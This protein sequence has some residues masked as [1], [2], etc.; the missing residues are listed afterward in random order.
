MKTQALRFTLILLSTLTL[1]TFIPVSVAQIQDYSRVN[2]P[3]GAIVRLGKGGVSYRDRG[4]AFSPDGTKLAIG[5]GTGNNMVELW[6]VSTRKHIATFPGHIGKVSSVAF[7][8]DGTKLASGSFDG[9]V[10]LWDVPKS[11]KLYPSIAHPD[12]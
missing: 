4:I 8:P 10:L 11:I 12:R 7:S 1:S 3:D 2:L 9:T 5:T 6:D